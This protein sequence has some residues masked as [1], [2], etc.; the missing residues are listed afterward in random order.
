[1]PFF[2]PNNSLPLYKS[3][4]Y[5]MLRT[6]DLKLSLLICTL[7]LVACSSAGDDIA[8]QAS[9]RI[10]QLSM[11]EY[12]DVPLI[13]NNKEEEYQI[14]LSSLDAGLLQYPDNMKLLGLRVSLHSALGNEE[15][16]KRDVEHMLTLNPKHLG[17]QSMLCFINKELGANPAQVTQCFRKT[18]ELVRKKYTFT[19]YGDPHEGEYIAYLLLGKDPAAKELS[20]GYLQR[21]Q[22]HNPNDVWMYTL[23]FDAAADGTFSYNFGAKDY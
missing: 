15:L 9:E 22:K 7:L 1:M 14:V 16:A 5:L 21:L 3:R 17:A 2:E 4:K 6:T 12:Y 23:L 13:I 8:R 10:T 11:A 20:E 18:A 19:P